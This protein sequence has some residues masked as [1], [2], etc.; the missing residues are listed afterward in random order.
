[1][2]Y[3]ECPSPLLACEVAKLV[4]DVGPDFLV[5]YRSVGDVVAF[6]FHKNTDERVPREKSDIGLAVCGF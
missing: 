2:E 6:N 5:H 3:A 1:M 4:F